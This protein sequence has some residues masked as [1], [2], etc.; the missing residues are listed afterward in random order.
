MTTE[1]D[2]T[3]EQI[4]THIAEK[5]AAKKKRG[6]PKNENYL[7]W[8]EAREFMRGEM[9]PSRGKFFEWWSRNKPK[10]IPRFPYRVYKEWVS[11]NDFLGTDNKFNEKVGRSWRQLDE[12]SMW[13]HK[14]K[15]GSQAQWMDWCKEV[16]NLPV[17]IP[18]RP[19][20]VYDKW[21]S[22]KHWLGS[23]T[24]EAVEAKQQAQR[25]A[26]YYI[27]H[28]SDVPINVFTYGTDNGGLSALKE[29]WERE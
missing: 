20:L 12:A 15:L 3:E 17:D 11:W 8:G 25:H 6:R 28:E 9:I 26:V 22:W 5:Q 16:G 10:A 13:V 4:D 18:A 23:K 19:D 24:V 21:R 27:V 1:K 29:R 2:L 7:P 14:L